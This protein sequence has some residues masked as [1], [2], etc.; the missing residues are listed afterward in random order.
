MLKGIKE[1][2]SSRVVLNSKGK[3][4]ISSSAANYNAMSITI[5][6]INGKFVCVNESWEGVLLLK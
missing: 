6:K 1:G 5:Q 2:K 3:P 4:V